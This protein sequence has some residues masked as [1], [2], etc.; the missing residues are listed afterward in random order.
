MIGTDYFF[1]TKKILSTFQL[2]DFEMKHL[3]NAF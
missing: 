1:H 2:V 3:Q